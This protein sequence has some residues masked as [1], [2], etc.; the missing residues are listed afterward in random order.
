MGEKYLIFLVTHLWTHF[1][2]TKWFIFVFFNIHEKCIFQCL[3]SFLHK[4]MRILSNKVVFTVKRFKK[5][6]WKYFSRCP[7]KIQNIDEKSDLKRKKSYKKIHLWSGQ[8]QMNL[9]F[10]L[11][12]GMIDNLQTYVYLFLYSGQLFYINSNPG[13]TTLL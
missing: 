10:F 8:K 12:F 11:Q 2:L 13:I 3:Y 1:F 4:N 9:F 5:V 7:T 6:V